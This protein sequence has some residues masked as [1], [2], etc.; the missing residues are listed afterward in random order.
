MDTLPPES[1]LSEIKSMLT[2]ILCAIKDNHGEIGQLQ[3][4][5][6][7]LAESVARIDECS[8]AY[9]GRLNRTRDDL[10]AV[11]LELGE[12]EKELRTMVISA[13]AA[14]EKKLDVKADCKDVLENRKRLEDKADLSTLKQWVTVASIVVGIVCFALG[15]VLH[16]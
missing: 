1:S 6:Q 13:V 3:T 2:N 15:Y 4:R 9:Q 8:D 14:I 5:V 16:I 10:I 12:A 11:K 7:G